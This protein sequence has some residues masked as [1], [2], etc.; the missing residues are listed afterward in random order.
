MIVNKLISYVLDVLTIMGNPI[1][2]VDTTSGIDTDN[3]TNQPG[4]VVEKNPGSE[5]TREEGVQL[6]P[7]VM[8]TLQFMVEN[9]LN[10]LGSTTDVSRG[11]APAGD[12]SGYAIA[13]L[14]EAAQTKIRGKGRNVEIFLKE[15]GSLMVDRIL[16]FYQLPRVERIT[17]NTNAV[18]YFKF[19]I[20]EPMD[21]AGR[22]PSSW[23]IGAHKIAVIY[24]DG[25]V[26][27]HDRRKG[28]VD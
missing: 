14:Q 24:A 4:L 1:W 23:R 5:V 3:L 20:T 26:G 9:V 11:A 19:H 2:V 27:P 18:E 28:R 15:A 22:R 6:Q 13:Q 10:K 12:T 17:N 8:Q 7:Y 16:Q 21:E 25:A